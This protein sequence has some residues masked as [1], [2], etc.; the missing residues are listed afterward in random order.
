MIDQDISAADARALLTLHD[1]TPSEVSRRRFLQMVGW[2][3]GGGAVLGTVGNALPNDWFGSMREAHAAPL[4]ANEGVLI[5]VCLDGGNDGL[6][7]VVPF[8]KPQYAQYRSN[9]AIPEAQ[10]LKINGELGLNPNLTYLKTLWD[11]NEVAVVQGVG[12]DKHSQSHFDSMAFWMFGRSGSFSNSFMPSSGWVGRWLDG[13]GAESEQFKAVSVGS[14]LPLTLV[15]EG[16]R[17][18]AV[19]PYGIDYGGS[20]SAPN[21]RMYNAIKQFSSTSARRGIWHDTVALAEKSQIDTAQTV[22]PIFKTTVPSGELVR[23]M[24][25]AARLINADLG[26]RVIDTRI[27]ALDNHSNQPTDHN[28]QMKQFSDALA[29]FYTNISP[30]FRNRVTIMTWSEFGRTPWSNSS[31][32]TDHG[33]TNPHFVIGGNVKGG[34][35]GTH[36][37]MLKTNGQ[38]LGTNDRMVSSL[39]FRQMYATVIDGV[40]GGGAGAVLGGNFDKFDLIRTNSTPSTFGS[41]GSAGSQ[42]VGIVPARLIDTRDAGGAPLGAGQSISL[43]VAGYGGVG[44]GASAAVLNVTAVG[45]TAGSYLTVWPAGVTRPNTS[46]L[47]IAGLDV[48]PNLVISKLGTDGR[49]DIFNFAGDVHVVVDVV[50][51]FQ[52]TPASRFNGLSPARVLDTRVGTGA[53]VAPVLGGSSIDVQVAGV[54][55]VAGD[56]DSVVLNVTVTGPTT[57]G[58]ITVWPAGAAMPTASNLNFVPGQTVPNLVIAKLGAGGRV[59]MYNS[60]GASHLVADV[61]GYFSPNTGA[62]L[63]PIAPARLIDTRVDLGRLPVD[64]T[65]LPVKVLDR[66]G[67]PATGV[68]AVVL[69]VTATDGTANGYVTVFPNG[70]A[71]PLASNLNITAGSTRANLVIAKVGAD[72]SVALFNSNGTVHLIA[73]V[74][75]YFTE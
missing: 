9:I 29:A 22:S 61:L 70:E 63:I 51:F 16:R 30:A 3:V 23:Q 36:P 71:A 37:S 21:M 47:N 46:S 43:P 6:N 60:Q 5:L 55:G 33:T 18:L 40:L 31:L 75:G 2:G 12:Y 4:G 59:S 52:N 28:R 50:G 38:P 64:Q 19:S 41:T 65:P 58:F 44:A 32:G 27:G 68:S 10:L 66:G 73:D 20:T 67:V 7:T 11:Q 39:D 42:F 49:V 56:A 72:S 26:L 74:V 62:K 15:G 1:E 17:G 53:P 24:V 13:F 69:N 34:V 45:G 57:D 54:G 25:V 35:Y 14:G 8:T 48:V